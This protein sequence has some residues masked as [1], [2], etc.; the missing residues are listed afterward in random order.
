MPLD[1]TDHPLYDLAIEQAVK[2]TPPNLPRNALFGLE[3]VQ[4]LMALMWC[5]GVTWG[6]THPQE[7]VSATMHMGERVTAERD[8]P[9]QPGKSK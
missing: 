5:Q 4:Q 8:I 9:Q 2:L 1:M 3:H 6:V 7:A